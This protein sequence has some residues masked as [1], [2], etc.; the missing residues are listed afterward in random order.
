MET[1]NDLYV[2]YPLE[3][4]SIGAI[5]R[6]KADRYEDRAFFFYQ[7]DVCTYRQLCD[8][9][10]QFA[11][12]LADLG[13]QKEMVCNMMH[14]TPDY[15]YM[16]FGLSMIGGVEVPINTAYKGYLLEYLINYSGAEIIIIE[17]EFLD[18]I[19]LIEDKLTNLKKMI[20]HSRNTKSNVENPTCFEVLSFEKIFKDANHVPDVDVNY[21]DLCSI[22]FT[23]GTTGPSKGAMLPVNFI[24]R[25]STRHIEI[26][27]YEEKDVLYNFLPFYHVAAKF[28]TLAAMLVGGKI[29]LQEKFSVSAF[30]GN[31]KKYGITGFIA[32]GGIPQ[33]LYSRPRQKDDAEN[34]LKK[35]Y[36]VPRP[37]EL[38]D[39]FEKR[40]G[41]RM[42]EAYG[43]TEDG[44]V[45]STP[46]D[47]D[48]PKGS[49]GKASSLYQ[50][51]IVDEND[52][53]RPPGVP[54]EIVVR[55]NEPYA[56]MIGYHKMPD[57]TLEVFRNLWFHTGD[58]GVRDENG[59]FY[60]L[61]RM[62]D[63]IRRRGENISSYEVERV[64]DG[65][66]KVSESAVVA[67]PSEFVEDE[68][69]AFVVLK[70]GENLDPLDLIKYCEDR[71]QYFA[72]P[73]YVDYVKELPR[74][75][76]TKVEKY[77]LRE[78]GNTPDT[79]DMEKSGYE[80]KR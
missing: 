33:M 69:K 4:R 1:R 24:Y 59:W 41:V 31:V 73:R 22:V 68:V 43:A 70:E 27:R 9:A 57:E 30:W 54:G 2:E 25:L 66:P 61:D 45:L 65:H 72:V 19:K 29:V 49:C 39:D 17:D 55:S 6:D 64:I 76:T 21:S 38:Q 12:G 58:R 40:F 71:M 78:R 75:P 13:I 44:L 53:P 23:S 79:W 36:S 46:W 7:D 28:Q 11:A 60:F 10:S 37:K 80:L 50:V 3:K 48:V 47:E 56:I 15:L 74:T 32:V 20:V 51:D 8:R 26:M 62:N 77:K 18:R 14:S 52:M 5:L 63:S 34:P 16:W 42:M 35:V 67:V